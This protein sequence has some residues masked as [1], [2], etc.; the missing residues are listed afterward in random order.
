M[1]IGTE[2]PHVDHLPERILIMDTRVLF[3]DDQLP[4]DDQESNDAVKIAI[5][6]E[7]EEKLKKAEE[8]RETLEAAKKD[9]WAAKCEKMEEVS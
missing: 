1:V 7:I 6:E 4:Y 3:A 2:A 9:Q 5:F 8:R